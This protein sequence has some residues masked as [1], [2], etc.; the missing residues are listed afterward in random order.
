MICK[1]SPMQ[2]ITVD[3]SAMPAT[4]WKLILTQSD[5]QVI[6]Q[7]SFYTWLFLIDNWIMVSTSLKEQTPRFLSTIM[8]CIY[9]TSHQ[10]GC[11]L[12]L[13]AKVVG[14]QSGLQ[15]LSTYIWCCNSVAD[16]DVHVPWAIRTASTRQDLKWKL[17][18]ILTWDMYSL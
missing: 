8:T 18:L 7:R 12:Q 6:G 11:S 17:K 10:L 16:I 14:M 1:L 4:S 5:L 3:I 15:L 13:E 2:V 9:H